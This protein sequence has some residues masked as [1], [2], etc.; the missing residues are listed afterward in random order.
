MRLKFKGSL[1]G[2]GIVLL[3]VSFCTGAGGPA[4]E[5]AGDVVKLSDAVP[6]SRLAV[7][8]LEANLLDKLTPPTSTETIYFGEL[9]QFGNDPDN[10]EPIAALP[11]IAVRNG[12]LGGGAAGE[13]GDAGWRL[14]ICGGGAGGEGDLGSD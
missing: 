9:D 6:L 2:G 12:E 4:T 10:D 7:D 3:V 13:R 1:W 11:I 14:A 5:P 8:E